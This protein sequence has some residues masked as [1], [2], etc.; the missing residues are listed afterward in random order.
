M[1]TT[2]REFLKGA[3]AA[4]T[5]GLL[6]ACTPALRTTPAPT[7]ISLG[8]AQ[9]KLDLG[10]YR[11]PTLSSENIQLRF[12]RQIA[13]P[14]AEEYYKNIYAQWAEAYPNITIQEETVP[15]GDL[16][17]K[18]QTYVAA[19]DPPD[20]MMGKGDFV[21]AYVYNN[22]AL[23]LSEYLTDDFLDDLTVAAKAQLLVDG[24]LYAWPQESSQIMV[25]FNKDL[26]E[27][28]GIEMPPETSNLD[29]GWTW[30]QFEEAWKEL[31]VALNENPDEPTIYPLASSTYGN[32]G[33][34]FQL[35]L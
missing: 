10:A 16:V 18:I 24:N 28:A 11:G 21:Q 12:L 6:A 14:A 32:G 4:A 3:S 5:I 27:Q 13:T 19:G 7:T 30:T 29:E 9:Y 8:S 25:Y 15:Y 26:W 23:N 2:R 31:L 17:T 22:I 34:W 35:L 1:S 20:I 33:T